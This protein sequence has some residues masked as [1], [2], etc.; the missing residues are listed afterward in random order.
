MFDGLGFR[1]FFRG[2]RVGLG[3]V[4]GVGGGGGFGEGARH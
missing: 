4:G 3:V 1:N 2:S